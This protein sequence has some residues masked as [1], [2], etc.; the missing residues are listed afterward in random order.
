[1]INDLRY[2]VTFP[3]N[4]V[5]LSGQLSFQ[6][7]ATAISGRN[8]TG[9]SFVAEMIRYG[10]FGAKARRGPASDYKSLDM[11]L[12]FA[13]G[14][15]SYTVKRGKKEELVCW[16]GDEVLAVGADAVN[17]KIVELLG[18]ELE[19]FDVVCAANQKESE[20]L[21]RLTPAKRK[22]LIDDVVGLTRQEAVE[23]ACREEAKN[24]RLEAETLSRALVPP[25]EPVKP[26]LYRPSADI[27]AELD[28]ANNA[29]AT[30]AELQRII[31]AVPPEPVKPPKPCP[32]IEALAAHEVERVRISATR[33]ALERNIASIPDPLYTRKQLEQ[34]QALADYDAE[35]ERRGPQPS[36]GLSEEVI[37][38]TLGMWA[39]HHALEEIGDIEVHCPNCQHE[40]QPGHSSTPPRLDERRLQDELQRV[41]AWA[42]ELVKPKGTRIP[43]VELAQ[44][45]KALD[46][47]DEKQLMRQELEGLPELED[48]SDE[49][50]EARQL[51]T[52]WEVYSR[53]LD[54]YAACAAEAG[55]AQYELDHLPAPKHSPEDLNAAYTAAVVYERELARYEADKQR[56]DELSAEIAEKQERADAFTAGAKGLVEARRTLKA[57]LAPSLS[58]VASKIIGEMTTNAERPLETIIV[59]EDMN[60]TAD[61]Q[62]VSTFNG[63]HATMIN[64]A[65][66]LALGQVLVARVFPVFIGDEL[67]SDADEANA[68]AIADALMACR[69]QLRQVVIISH[70]RLEGVDHQVAL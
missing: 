30:R 39:K 57:F 68:Q 56:F 50:A 42:D 22:E 62:D 11:A 18:F 33:A 6:P 49:L 65:L 51:H 4:G 52:A 32:D 28:E 61:G 64:L 9:K 15:V 10:L 23:K 53:Q 12:G 16:D 31:G 24:A 21:T 45:V 13:I 38:T 60:I 66:R 43:P 37:V 47:A 19:V 70:K 2:A 34:A 25:T 35:V 3:T 54:H 27:K 17:K 40:F 8:G 1:M 29:V 44:A 20:R 14:D 67:D 58:R 7:G 26:D 36:L 41:R 46:R 59:D 69:E 5:A 48:K 63:A 55:N